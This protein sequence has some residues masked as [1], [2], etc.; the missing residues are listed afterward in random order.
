MS[1]AYMRKLMEAF[2]ASQ[3][4]TNRFNNFVSELEQLSAKYG[5]ILTVSGGV[6]I[7]DEVDTVKYDRDPTSGDLYPISVNG[8]P[9]S[10]IY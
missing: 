9:W 10:E 6:N 3:E 2:D 8:K 4:E 1:S 7:V 5:V